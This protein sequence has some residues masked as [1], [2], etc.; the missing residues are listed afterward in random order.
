LVR[1]VNDPRK[2]GRKT[3]VI[4]QLEATCVLDCAC[5]LG[6]GPIWNHQLGVLEFVDI[7]SGRLHRFD[8][9][10]GRHQV[11]DVGSHI[12]CF[13]PRQGGGYVVGVKDGFGLV[14]PQGGAVEMVAPVLA[15]HP[16]LR[17]NDGK[18]D[19]RGR[20]FA[21]SMGYDFTPG[22]GS[23]YRF[24]PDG[25][26]HTVVEGVTVSNGLD[27]TDDQR[28][29]YYV[30]SMAYGVDR[31]DYDVDSGAIANRRRAIDVANDTAAPMGMTVADGITLDS[32]GALW[33]AMH[34]S[35]EVRRHAPDG[36]L[37]QTVTIPP[38]GATSVA[39]G[40]ENLDELYITCAALENHP[41]PNG[42]GIFRCRPG[43]S[44]RPANFFPA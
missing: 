4:A 23:L 16:E 24:D 26:V 37:L 32:E 42:G 35:G 21:G 8:P 28:T 15:G 22:A 5:L 19:P 6:E 40:G 29:M 11:T 14:G 34:G 9:R 7:L 17:M 44:G 18:C 38:V 27:W 33:V 39:F 2:K 30:D 20:F 31:F 13:A 36:T 25:S 3:P 43:V 10:S 12:G 41:A 1:I